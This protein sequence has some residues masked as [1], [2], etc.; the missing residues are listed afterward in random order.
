MTELIAKL[1]AEGFGLSEIA[2]ELT[3][4]G[5]PTARGGTWYASTVR[6]V[7]YERKATNRKP[8]TLPE[9]KRRPRRKGRVA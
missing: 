6:S 4:R 7:L 5:I 8:T 2:R 3:A 9:V 1:D